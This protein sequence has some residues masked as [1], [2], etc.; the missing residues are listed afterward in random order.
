MEKDWCVLALKMNTRTIARVGKQP[1]QTGNQDCYVDFQ[2]Y[3]YLHGIRVKKYI[4][5]Q[6]PN[7]PVRVI[8][9]IG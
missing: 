2:D 9:Y 8:E 7:T 3:P 6:D 4:Y 1:E 5:K